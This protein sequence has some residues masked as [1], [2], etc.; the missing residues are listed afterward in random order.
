M[1][2]EFYAKP[3]KMPSSVSYLLCSLIV[4]FSILAIIEITGLVTNI[5][6][7]DYRR[8]ILFIALVIFSA[9]MLMAILDFTNKHNTDKPLFIFDEEVFSFNHPK[10]GFKIKWQDLTHV[11]ESYLY[12][13]PTFI[14][15]TK[16][17]KFKLEQQYLNV[18]EN[19]NI[20][21]VFKDYAKKI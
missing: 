1:R 18:T 21:D 17:D 16:T 4:I 8:L 10:H 7:G 19:I 14:I 13:R 15:H 5:I 6:T 11:D 20:Y 3:I 9:G 12:N 2:K